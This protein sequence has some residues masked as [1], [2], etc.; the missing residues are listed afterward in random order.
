MTP[1]IPKIAADLIRALGDAL[2]LL[3]E[4]G[5]ILDANP[6]VEA[7]FGYA[8]EELLGKPLQLLLPQTSGH[9]PLTGIGAAGQP[10]MAAEPGLAR[11][12]AGTEFSVELTL[13]GF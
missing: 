8:P 10:A 9:P 3:S 5:A 12:K 13:T 4:E 1:M 6:A 7:M 11:N 2:V